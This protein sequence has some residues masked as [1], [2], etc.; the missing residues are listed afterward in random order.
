MAHITTII[1]AILIASAVALHNWNES[2]NFLVQVLLG[3]AQSSERFQ[4]FGDTMFKNYWTYSL[5]R[6]IARWKDGKKTVCKHVY[7]LF[8]RFPNFAISNN[9]NDKVR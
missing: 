4:R 5:S 6:D 3:K 7:H 1:A 8:S 9:V 2:G